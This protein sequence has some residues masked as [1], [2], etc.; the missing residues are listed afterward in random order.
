[1]LDLL[2]P[3]VMLVT[4]SLR[5]MAPAAVALVAT[6]LLSDLL[7]RHPVWFVVCSAH[8]GILLRSRYFFIVSALPALHRLHLHPY[9]YPV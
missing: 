9:W 8:F 2:A 4:P 5:R 7:R 1:M 3:V 6:L